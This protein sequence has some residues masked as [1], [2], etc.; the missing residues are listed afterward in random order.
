MNGT[1]QL[2]VYANEINLVGKKIERKTLGVAYETQDACLSLNL[3]SQTV[4][5]CAEAIYS[6]HVYIPVRQRK[7]VCD[8]N[9][10]IA[11][12]VYQVAQNN[13]LSH[14]CV[15]LYE[16]LFISIL[17]DICQLGSET[18]TKKKLLK[19]WRVLWKILW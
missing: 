1:Y 15:W 4:F 17:I 8:R 18:R 9:S 19:L 10:K 3:S 2:A 12:Q 6:L 7:F 13:L 5:S 11:F 14:G 16:Q